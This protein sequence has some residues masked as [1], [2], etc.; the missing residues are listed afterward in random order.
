MGASLNPCPKNGCLGENLPE[1]LQLYPVLLLVQ[2]D[3]SQVDR[4]E[5]ELEISLMNS[6]TSRGFLVTPKECRGMLSVLNLAAKTT[7][8]HLWG[9]RTLSGDTSPRDP[10]CLVARLRRPAPLGSE[11]KCQQAPVSYLGEDPCR[12]ANVIM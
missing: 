7:E 8:N 11:T 2:D 9:P 6:L 3:R 10:Q 1:K 12:V 5:S 4:Q